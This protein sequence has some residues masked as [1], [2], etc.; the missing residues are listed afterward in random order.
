M[1]LGDENE[2]GGFGLFEVL[3]GR[4]SQGLAKSGARV[5]YMGR[6]ESKGKSQGDVVEARSEKERQFF[7][8]YPEKFRP[9]DTE[10]ESVRGPLKRANPRSTNVT[11]GRASAPNEAYYEGASAEG[12]KTLP[13]T[14]K[15]RDDSESRALS[16]SS[17][18]AESKGKHTPM[19][20]TQVEEVDMDKLKAMPV[21]EL[22]TWARERHID[23]K[24][25]VKKDDILKNIE[26]EISKD[27][28]GEPTETPQG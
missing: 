17:E 11:E 25:A 7:L 4:H 5:T 20:E 2:P 21:R 3:A 1:P 26:T 18:S 9:V 16:E 24:G 8:K 23:I 6:Q 27:D 14:S 22:L 12:A 15:P 28:N 13:K 10:R 19:K